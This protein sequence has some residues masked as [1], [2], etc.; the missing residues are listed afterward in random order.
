MTACRNF[1]EMTKANVE[2]PLMELDKDVSHNG[3]VTAISLDTK[4]C[5]NVE[6]LLDKCQ[7]CQLKWQ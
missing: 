2:F 5:L 4:K 3:V 1:V 7:A 6:I